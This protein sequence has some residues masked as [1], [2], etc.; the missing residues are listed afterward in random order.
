MGLR[1][2]RTV[3][4]FISPNS[5]TG[6]IIPVIPSKNAKDRGVKHRL[7]SVNLKVESVQMVWPSITEGNLYVAH[8]QAGAI[9]VLDASGFKYGTIRL[10]KDA[11]DFIPPI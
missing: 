11:G 7:S 4:V 1:F 3:N 6:W 8:F 5:S 10:P 2:Q 9:V